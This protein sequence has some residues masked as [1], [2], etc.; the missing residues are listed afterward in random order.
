MGDYSQSVLPIILIM[1]LF[2]VIYKW[3]D[4]HI[5]ITMST[6]FVPFLSVAI[7]QPFEYCLLAPLGSW[8]GT[9]NL[10][11]GIIGVVIAVAVSAALTFFIG[12]TPEQKQT[13]Q[14]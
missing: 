8:L 11:N 12:F 10:V 13:G 14:A 5:P 3:L 2:S 6:L 9:A 4:K 7:I 1:P